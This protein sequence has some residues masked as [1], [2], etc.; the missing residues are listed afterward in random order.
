MLCSFGPAMDDDASGLEDVP[1]STNTTLEPRSTHSHRGFKAL[2]AKNPSAAY[3][4]VRQ[5]TELTHQR[6]LQ[7]QMLREENARL[8]LM[9]NTLKGVSDDLAS[10]FLEQEHGHKN[11]FP[12]ECVLPACIAKQTR[13][14]MRAQAMSTSDE[15]TTHI[16]NDEEV[17]LPYTELVEYNVIRNKKIHINLILCRTS[18]NSIDQLISAEGLR[19]E[20]LDFQFEILRS[21]GRPFAIADSV[22]WKEGLKE[23]VVGYKGTTLRWCFNVA[24]L[25]SEMEHSSIYV[26]VH[27]K[28]PQFQHIAWMSPRFM[29]KARRDHARYRSGQDELGE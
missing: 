7:N 4:L 3:T 11:K 16:M 5:A 12:H 19:S 26:H 29:I 15:D 18:Q 1:E 13:K 9:N 17:A 25:S 24:M 2:C 22:E 14:R 8:H 21:D 6:N 28:T 20:G 27:C 10:I 23:Q